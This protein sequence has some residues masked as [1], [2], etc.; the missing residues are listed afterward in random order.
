MYPYIPETNFEHSVVV[1]QS[2]LLKYSSA[3]EVVLDLTGIM[4]AN[5]LQSNFCCIGPTWKKLV[6]HSQTDSFIKYKI[7]LYEHENLYEKRGVS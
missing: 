6:N 1:I 7:I 2:N 4:E 5:H 3:L